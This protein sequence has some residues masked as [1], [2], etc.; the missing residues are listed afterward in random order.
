MYKIIKYAISQS[1]FYS[2][3]ITI[4]GTAFLISFFENFYFA[5][6]LFI[7]CFFFF[8]VLT[9]YE[10]Y[11]FKKINNEEDFWDER[12]YLDNY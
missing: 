12:D 9:I 10:W 6:L 8:F 3:L 7:C 4:V 11:K 5:I 2:S 1:L